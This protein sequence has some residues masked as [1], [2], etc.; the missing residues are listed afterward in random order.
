MGRIASPFVPLNVKC[1]WIL[2]SQNKIKLRWIFISL[3]RGK[4]LHD[5]IRFFPLFLNQK[6]KAKIAEVIPVS[7]IY[8]KSFLFLI[9]LF[10]NNFTFVIGNII[11]CCDWRFYWFIYQIRIQRINESNK[12][13]RKR[14]QLGNWV[15]GDYSLLCSLP[16]W[17][18]WFYDNS[19]L[20]FDL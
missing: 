6:L 9:E 19:F 15:T 20:F 7:T 16:D 2:K 8:G 13:G 17:C 10:E 14:Y 11:Y 18:D 1:H 4:E 12:P 5:P 3:K